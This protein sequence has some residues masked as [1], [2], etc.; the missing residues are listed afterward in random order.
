MCGIFDTWPETGLANA[1]AVEVT[2]KFASGGSISRLSS[3][4]FLSLGVT[5]LDRCTS[6]EPAGYR[7]CLPRVQHREQVGFSRLHRT[8]ESVQLWQAFL[9]GGP[10]FLIFMFDF[11][12]M[13]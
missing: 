3:V 1:V 7:H 12:F 6:P 10:G 9:R 2:E 13:M 11:E 8:L 4:E 5:G